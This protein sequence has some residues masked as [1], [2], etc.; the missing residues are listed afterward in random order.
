MNA[1]IQHWAE[2]VQSWNRSGYGRAIISSTGRTQISELNGMAN[3][4][5]SDIVK[6]IKGD[7]IAATALFVDCDYS[8][9]PLIFTSGDWVGW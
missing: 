4:P 1:L 3:A 9:N 7:L 6:R 2:G 5:F 8:E